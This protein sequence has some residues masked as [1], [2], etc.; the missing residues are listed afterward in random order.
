MTKENKDVI[1]LS[2][3]WPENVHWSLLHVNHQHFKTLW[4]ALK[5]CCFT[6]ESFGCLQDTLKSEQG[7]DYLNFTTEY[8]DKLHNVFPGEKLFKWKKTRLFLHCDSLFSS[9]AF[10]VLW[11]APANRSISKN[12]NNCPNFHQPLLKDAVNMTLLQFQIKLFWLLKTK[13]Y[14]WYLQP[15]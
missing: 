14:C 9:L 11:I 5:L 15:L 8:L 13:S 3:P 6:R 2:G 10:F 1:F 4:L 7:L 12:E